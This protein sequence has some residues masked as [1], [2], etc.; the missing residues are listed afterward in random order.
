MMLIVEWRKLFHGTFQGHK[1]IFKLFLL[2]PDEIQFII[3]S[4][5]VNLHSVD[6]V[7]QQVDLFPVIKKQSIPSV[8]LSGLM[9]KCLFLFFQFQHPFVDLFFQLTEIYLSFCGRGR[10]AP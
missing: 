4:L 8:D 6:I 3:Q 9:K 7:I 10:R 1:Q 2:G 5:L